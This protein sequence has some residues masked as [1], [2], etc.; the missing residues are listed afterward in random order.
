MERGAGRRGPNLLA[1]WTLDEGIG[2]VAGD[3]SGLGNAGELGALAGPGRRRS[4]VGPAATTA[5]A[6]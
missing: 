4:H 1:H 5:A 6:R 3:T 2:Q